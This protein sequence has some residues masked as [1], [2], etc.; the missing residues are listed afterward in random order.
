MNANY[1]VIIMQMHVEGSKMH[2][3]PHRYAQ[4][5]HPLRNDFGVSSPFLGGILALL[6]PQGSLFLAKGTHPSDLPY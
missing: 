2:T 4:T 1:D 6:H 5:L 3:H